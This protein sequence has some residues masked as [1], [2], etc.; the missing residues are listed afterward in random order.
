MLSSALKTF[1]RRLPWDRVP[2]YTFHRKDSWLRQC[3]LRL[4]PEPTSAPAN[5]TWPPSKT[6]EITLSN[7][8]NGHKLGALARRS[9]H[10]RFP[11]FQRGHPFL[12][13]IDRRLLTRVSVSKSKTKWRMGQNVG[14]TDVHHAGISEAKGFQSEESGSMLA[15]LK[16]E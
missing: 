4:S 6:R 2:G 7:C 16:G 8:S 13:H 5:V 11:S 14:A 1:S 9:C 12:E 3:C 15:V 10:G